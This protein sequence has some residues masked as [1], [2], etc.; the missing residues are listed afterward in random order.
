M[1]APGFSSGGVMKLVRKVAI[2]LAAAAAGLL[3]SALP[4]AAADGTDAWHQTIVSPDNFHT[5]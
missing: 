2:V 5:P 4:A 3:T 1:P